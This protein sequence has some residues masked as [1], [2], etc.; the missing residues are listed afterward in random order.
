MACCCCCCAAHA[1][2]KGGHPLEKMI[3]ILKAQME[4]DV[5]ERAFNPSTQENGFMSSRPI[6]FT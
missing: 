3:Y 1:F 5:V 6:W 2:L 4:L